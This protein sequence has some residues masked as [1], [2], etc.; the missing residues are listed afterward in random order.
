MLINHYFTVNIFLHLFIESSTSEL[1]GLPFLKIG[2]PTAVHLFTPLVCLFFQLELFLYFS[3]VY[4]LDLLVEV[5]VYVLDA[6]F[7]LG[8][9]LLFGKDVVGEGGRRSSGCH[10]LVQAMV[11][12]SFLV[13]KLLVE[14]SGLEVV[15]N[16]DA[17][18]T[19]MI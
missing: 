1:L 17:G 9:G 10:A 5:F 6:M 16:V 11:S 4:F 19:T 3:V 18:V 14:V 12:S 15:V 13:G 8:D 7:E 2:K